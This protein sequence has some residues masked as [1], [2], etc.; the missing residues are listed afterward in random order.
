VA[1]A[2]AGA[3]Q[4]K[5]SARGATT[6][7]HYEP[8]LPAY[9]HRVAPWQG[10][11]AGFLAGLLA[12]RKATERSDAIVA[13]LQEEPLRLGAHV[14]MVLYH[15]L[16]DEIESAAD[17][18]AKAVERRDINLTFFIRHPLLKPLRSS[19]RWSALLDTMNLPTAE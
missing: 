3:L 10:Y 7:V 16:R 4:V 15:V 9:A 5:F 6:A 11:V 13:Q 12:K 14:G 1:A 18:C 8:R 17:W 19:T 2:I